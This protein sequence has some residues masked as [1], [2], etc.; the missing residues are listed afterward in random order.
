MG[1]PMSDESYDDI[2]DILKEHVDI[3]RDEFENMIKDVLQ[4][5]EN[6]LSRRGAAIIIAKKYGI[7]T[8]KIVYPPII[9]RLIEVGPIRTAKSPSGQ[10]PFVLFALV[11][12]KKRVQGVAFGSRHVNI[13]RS[14]EDRALRIRG[15]TKARLERYSGIKVTERSTIEILDDTT[16]PPIQKLSHAWAPS[17]KFIKENRGAWLVKC[18]ALDQTSTEYPACP[19]CGKAIDMIEDTWICPEHGSIDTPKYEKIWR[20]ILSDRSGVFPAVY[21]KKLPRD[22][23]VNRLITVKGYFKDE[24]FYIMRFYS[25][26]EDEIIGI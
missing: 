8:T 10:T 21:F 4:R 20:F 19:I 22:S 26:S 24:E 15:Y 16:L 11:N 23:L 9:G 5:Y 17:L 2:F 3:S 12:E 18:I 14:S 1:A 13:L 25:V 6:L 7:N